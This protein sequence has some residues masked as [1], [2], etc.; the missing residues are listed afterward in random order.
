MLDSIKIK[1]DIVF[2]KVISVFQSL[3]ECE[4]INKFTVFYHFFFKKKRPE[5]LAGISII[6]DGSIFFS[7]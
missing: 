2:L 1:D 7:R 6:T 4:V 3:D 5:R